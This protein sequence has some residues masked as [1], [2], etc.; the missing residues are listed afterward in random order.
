MYDDL[1]QQT[2][3]FL[4]ELHSRQEKQR[5]EEEESAKLKKLREEEVCGNHMEIIQVCVAGECSVWNMLP[6]NFL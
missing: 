5:I 6:C 1:F 3:E 2:E 4:V